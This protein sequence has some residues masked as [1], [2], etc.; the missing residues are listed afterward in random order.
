MTGRNK[1]ASLILQQFGAQQ[2]LSRQE[3]PQPGLKLTWLLRQLRQLAFH[4]WGIGRTCDLFLSSGDLSPASRSTP[5]M[6]AVESPTRREHAAPPPLDVE[7]RRICCG[8]G[9]RDSECENMRR[10]GPVGRFSWRCNG[11]MLR[12]DAAEGCCCCV[13]QSFRD[14]QLPRT[15]V[16]LLQMFLYEHIAAGGLHERIP[17]MLSLLHVAPCCI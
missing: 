1:V 5:L 11:G 14:E 7:T 12:R 10:A 3:R 4:E 8:A 16:F 9:E 13:S 2:C 15:Q 17:E 6:A